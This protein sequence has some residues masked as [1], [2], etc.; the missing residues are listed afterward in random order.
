MQATA[1]ETPTRLLLSRVLPSP[2][3]DAAQ[4]R[5]WDALRHLAMSH[6]VCLVTRS[7]RRMHL[8]QWRL[9]GEIADRVEV[10]PRGWFGFERRWSRAVSALV[11]AHPGAEVACLDG[12]APARDH[13]VVL[14][15][16]P[17]LTGSMKRAA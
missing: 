17:G 3:G 9:L 1:E 13:P 16:A 11:K 4:R 15:I 12:P 8:V 2:D 10:V 6:R 7:P 14:T 5:A